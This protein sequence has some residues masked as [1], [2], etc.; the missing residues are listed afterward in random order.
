MAVEGPGTLFPMNTC[1]CWSHC[2][3]TDGGVQV[4]AGLYVKTNYSSHHIYGVKV[5]GEVG[6]NVAPSPSLGMPHGRIN[7]SRYWNLSSLHRPP[8]SWLLLSSSSSTS[9][10]FLFLSENHNRATQA[11][12][13]NLP[14]SVAICDLMR[15]YLHGLY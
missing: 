7:L 9:F 11:L 4:A 5:G 10:L 1:W 3:C 6:G 15:P 12:S 13:K 14:S 2:M 8:A